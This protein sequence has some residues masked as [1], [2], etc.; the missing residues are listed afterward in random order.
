M[1]QR[2]TSLAH[3]RRRTSEKKWPEAQAWCERRNVN[4]GYVL[5]KRPDPSQGGKENGL[6]VLPCVPDYH[7]WWCDPDNNCGVQ[8]TRDH[9]FKHCSRWQAQLW[10]RAKKETR[11]EGEAE[12]A[13]KGLVG[14]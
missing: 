10:A 7:C 5:R 11:K 6:T 1:T 3:L 8:Q 2:P 12:V 14:G 9:L 4:Q 13:S